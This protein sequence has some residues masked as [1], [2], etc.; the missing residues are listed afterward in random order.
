MSVSVFKELKKKYPNII[1]VFAYWPTEK[2][3]EYKTSLYD[4]ILY[5]EGLE[6]VPQRFAI[7]HRN[8]WIVEQSDYLITY[9]YKSYGRTYEAF[10]YAKRR[11]KKIT[12]PAKTNMRK[13]K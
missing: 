9:A 3:L 5:P 10:Q 11:G 13:L 2:R 12:N 4:T 1:L 8:R 6:T 7:H